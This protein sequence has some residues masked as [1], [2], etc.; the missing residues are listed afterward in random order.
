MHPELPIIKREGHMIKLSSNP[1]LDYRNELLLVVLQTYLTNSYTYQII[2]LILTHQHITLDDMCQSILIS[3]THLL[4]IIN[5]L[6]N[7]LKKHNLMIRTQNNKLYLAGNIID[8]FLLSFL[9]YD[10]HTKI[11]KTSLSLDDTDSHTLYQQFIMPDNT[12]GF[13]Y[14]N[15]RR[16]KN[17]KYVIETSLSQLNLL[18]FSDLE[19]AELLELISKHLPIYNPLIVPFSK[20]KATF[21]YLSFMANILFTE[22]RSKAMTIRGFEKI[23]TSSHAFIKDVMVIANQLERLL[24]VLTKEQQLLFRGE[25]LLYFIYYK[26]YPSDLK[27]IFTADQLIHHARHSKDCFSYLSLLEEIKKER[28]QLP[29]DCLAS[30][31]FLTNITVFDHFANVF[32]YSIHRKKLF[33]T[34]DFENNLAFENSLKT[35]L[36]HLFNKD[37]IVINSSYFPADLIISDQLY[38]SPET[39]NFFYLPDPFSKNWNRSLLAYI[40]S[41]YFDKIIPETKEN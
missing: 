32:Y 22:L 27:K 8:T 4:R 25:F 7:Y 9:M 21:N 13:N 18:A 10:Y 24:P 19:T 6:N 37:T 41:I 31:L 39:E 17:F 5:K 12:I 34:L 11:F 29:K 23:V 36:N 40:S 30:D 33:I 20:N 26:L 16:A 14:A 38:H 35:Q 2:Q 1:R 28:V 15:Y 3:Q